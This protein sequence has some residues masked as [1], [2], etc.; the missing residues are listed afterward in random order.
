MFSGGQG[1]GNRRAARQSRPGG[2]GYNAAALALA[3]A[4]L[5]QPVLAAALMAGSSLMVI[6]NSRRLQRWRLRAVADA[7]RAASADDGLPASDPPAPAAASTVEGADRV[8]PSRF[9]PTARPP[10]SDG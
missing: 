2:F 6:A 1:G 10:A 5:L 4:G 8:R 3:A 9:A 7:P